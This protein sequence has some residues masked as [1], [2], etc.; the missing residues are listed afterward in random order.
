MRVKQ[1]ETVKSQGLGGSPPPQGN[2]PQ[3]ASSL[4]LAFAH[5]LAL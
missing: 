3:Q 2:G 1:H 4:L 5:A